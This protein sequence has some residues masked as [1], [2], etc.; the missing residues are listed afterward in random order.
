MKKPKDHFWREN[1][2]TIK[3]VDSQPSYDYDGLDNIS[4][5]LL[6]KMMRT[7]SEFWNGV[8]VGPIRLVS[9]ILKTK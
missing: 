6:F 8:P 5:F 7:D 3:W 1:K 2:D 9:W 4:D